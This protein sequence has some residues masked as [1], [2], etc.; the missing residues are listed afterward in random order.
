VIFA[1]GPET[2]AELKRLSLAIGQLQQAQQSMFQQFQMVQELRRAELAPVPGG[3]PAYG[4]GPPPGNY[5][6][7]ERQRD[8]RER[9]LKDLDAEMQRLYARYRELEEEKR[10]LLE[11]MNELTRSSR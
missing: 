9:R 5:E 10:P 7:L 8:E 4:I 3:P 2:D 11:Q 6:D 1:A